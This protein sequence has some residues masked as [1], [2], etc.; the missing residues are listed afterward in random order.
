MHLLIWWTASMA[1][2]PELTIPLTQQVFL[3]EQ[4]GKAPWKGQNNVLKS[5]EADGQGRMPM[6]R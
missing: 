2:Q 5:S 6:A 3:R 4:L 1:T